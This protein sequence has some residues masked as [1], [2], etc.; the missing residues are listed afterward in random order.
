MKRPILKALDTVIVSHANTSPFAGRIGFIIE[1]R[2]DN[3]ERETRYDVQFPFHAQIEGAGY[4]TRIFQQY[5]FGNNDITLL[6]SF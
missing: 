3:E 4:G 6:Q 2:N 5:Q 1:V